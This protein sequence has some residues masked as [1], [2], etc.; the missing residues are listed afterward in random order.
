MTALATSVVHP[1]TVRR[2]IASGWDTEKAR[3]TPST[4]DREDLVGRRFGRLIV[5]AHIESKRYQNGTYHQY[6]NCRCDCGNGTITTSQ[7]LKKN[8]CQS[9]GCLRLE[10]AKERL[11]VHGLTGTR[12]HRAW[13]SMR[14]RCRRPKSRIYKYYGGRGIVIC[15]RWLDSFEAFLADMG[16]CPAGYT[17]ERKEVNGN[18]EPGNCCWIP[19]AEQSKNRRPFRRHADELCGDQDL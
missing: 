7:R 9:C 18:Y 3:A 10:L 4:K 15:Q 5:V 2:R 11:R 13:A 8:T 1:Q 16:P 19:K 14:D 6:W 12:E 17:I